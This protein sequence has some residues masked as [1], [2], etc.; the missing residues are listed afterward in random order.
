MMAKKFDELNGVKICRTWR[1]K[2]DVMHYFNI[3]F[4]A[5]EELLDRLNN[6][7][8]LARI[9][10]DKRYLFVDIRKI[11]DCATCKYCGS[12]ADNDPHCWYGRGQGKIDE[13]RICDKYRA[14]MVVE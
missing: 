14:K 7:K 12:D 1:S 3:D 2:A 13:P 8:M 6:G 10:D 11:A 4:E 5:A 9:V